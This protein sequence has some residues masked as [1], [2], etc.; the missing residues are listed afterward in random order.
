MKTEFTVFTFFKKGHIFMKRKILSSCTLFLTA[1]IWG[2]AF[3]AQVK[4]GQYLGSFTFNGIRFALGA[5]SLIPVIMI[6]EIDFSDKKKLRK[7]FVYSL[8]AGSAIFIAS[9][10]QQIGAAVTQSS[11][12]SG[13]ITG[14]YNILTPIAYLF[15]F[16]KK[17]S[18]C[19]WIGSVIS[20]IGLFMLCMT[21]EGLHFGLGEISLL[22]GTVFWTAHILIVDRIVSEVYTLK[23]ACSQFLV[24]SIL[25]IIS[26]LIFEYKD[27]SLENVEKALIAILYCGLLSVGVAYTLQIVGQKYSASPTAAAIILSTESV[28]GAIGGVQFGTDSISALGYI[29]CVLIFVS[30]VLSQLPEGM[31]KRK[32]KKLK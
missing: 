14:I 9:T 12:V 1:I 32:A 30:I 19:V 23:F 8:L 3:V 20:I 5:L 31:F 16:K 17:T 25:S 10:L 26:A 11:G 4:G 27:F 21:E 13:F 2:Y 24:C 22:A 29:G 6:I 7:T 18:V 15:I 28:F